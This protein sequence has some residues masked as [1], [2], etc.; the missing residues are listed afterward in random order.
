MSLASGVDDM[1]FVVFSLGC[2]VNQYEGRS[3]INE[4]IS[5]GY[6]ATDELVCADCY[7]INTCSVTAEA[8]R[9]SRQAVSRVLK[10]NP[11]AKVVICGCSSQND[12]KP[13]KNKPNVNI[14]SGTSGKMSLVDSIMCDIIA[15]FLHFSRIIFPRF[16]DLPLYLLYNVYT[17][18]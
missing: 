18:L 4:L 17:L 9:K 5:R 6:E 7:I 13:Y 16:L 14:I 2:R 10:L 3:L 15:L 8:D 11:G 1:K 12:A